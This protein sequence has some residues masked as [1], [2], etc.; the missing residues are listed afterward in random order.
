MSQ[1]IE[2]EF[3]SK[4]FRVVESDHIKGLLKNSVEIGVANLTGP[5][6]SSFGP[7][8]T[9]TEDA[10]YSPTAAQICLNRLFR[11]TVADT[12]ATVP[13][14]NIPTIASIQ[15]YLTQTLGFSVAVGFVLEF[16]VTLDTTPTRN[17]NVRYS[18]AALAGGTLRND[19]DLFAGRTTKFQILFTA[20]GAVPTAD[21]TSTHS[22][23]S[24]LSNAL[25]AI[26]TDLGIA[27]N[28]NITATHIQTYRVLYGTPPGGGSAWQLPGTAAV[29]AL[30]GFEGWSRKISIINLSGANTITIVAGV[31]ETLIGNAVIAVSS[32]VTIVYHITNFVTNTANVFIF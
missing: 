7:V 14:F 1:L 6:A 28:I 26:S 27:A 29:T 24:Q 9:T 20:V 31:G 19:C 11:I 5:S 32:G 23:P 13:V 15:T 2:H 18:V 3:P 10:I 17:P 4:A 30:G 25:F 22:S 8:I 21:I 16:M 12:L